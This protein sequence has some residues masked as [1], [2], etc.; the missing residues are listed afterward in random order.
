MVVSNLRCHKP[1]IIVDLSMNL[2]GDA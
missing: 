2:A 1:E